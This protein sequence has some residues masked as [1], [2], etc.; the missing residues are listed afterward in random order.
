MKILTNMAHL[1]Y[2]PRW[3]HTKATQQVW[4]TYWINWLSNC[5]NKD[6]GNR[7]T[8]RRTDGQTQVTTITLRPKRPRVK[9]SKEIMCNLMFDSVAANSPWARPLISAAKIWSPGH[10]MRPMN[11]PGDPRSHHRWSVWRPMNSWGF[12]G[13]ISEWN[14]TYDSIMCP[15]VLMPK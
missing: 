10:Q 7:Q 15:F 14:W 3:C 6:D 13:N 4:W 9:K 5:V 2:H 12:G 11:P 1:Q 8:D